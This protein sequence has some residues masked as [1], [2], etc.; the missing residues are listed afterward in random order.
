ME[1][2]Q[3]P[4]LFIGVV[5][6]QQWHDRVSVLTGEDLTHF[7]EKCNLFKDARNASLK[8]VMGMTIY[9]LLYTCRHINPKFDVNEDYY[10]VRIAPKKKGG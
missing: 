2:E 3:K 10:T 5:T 6:K 1:F 8:K 7:K 4:G 9:E